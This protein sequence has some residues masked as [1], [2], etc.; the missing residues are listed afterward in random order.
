MKRAF[1]C[2]LLVMSLTFVPTLPSS[3]G[4]AQ[5][6]AGPASAD[7]APFGVPLAPPI[8]LVNFLLLYWSSP[9]SATYMPGYRAAL[10]Q[11]VYQC[12]FENP[13]GCHYGDMTKYFAEQALARGG[14]QTRTLHG[15]A[16]ARRTRD[17]KA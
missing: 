13:D 15:Q 10:P 4:P 8:Y 5:N 17:G 3:A 2:L 9:E 6:A 1:C 16:F 7:V 14:S 11:E 12:L